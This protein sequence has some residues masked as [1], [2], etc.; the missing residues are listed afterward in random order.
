MF[1]KVGVSMVDEKLFNEEVIQV[2]LSIEAKDLMNTAIQNHNSTQRYFIRISS[3]NY[4][5]GDSL[6]SPMDGKTFESIYDKELN[7]LVQL[8]V[9]TSYSKTQL[10]SNNPKERLFF[11]DLL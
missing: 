4:T 1:I 5:F 11:I 9:I 8:N 2:A 3:L 7:E 10:Q 6:D